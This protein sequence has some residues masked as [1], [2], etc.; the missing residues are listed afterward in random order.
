MLPVQPQRTLIEVSSTIGKISINVI[1]V[2]KPKAVMTI[3]H[4]AGAGME[5]PFMESLSQELA[6]ESI[7]TVR[8]NFP[9]MENRRGRPDPAPIAEKTVETVINKTHELY[10]RLPVFVSGKSF[11]G[12]MSSQRLSKD[13]PAFVKGIIFLGFPLHPAGAPA[14]DRAN[15]L[16]LISIPMLFLQ[17]TRDALAEMKLMEP[18]QKKL[19]LATLKKFEGADHSFKVSK[20][21]LLPELA[22]EA[23]LWIDHLI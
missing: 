9:Y 23:S 15:H 17:G 16:F 4:G 20:K 18:L 2:V 3:A 21:Q 10:P 12:R 14:T 7:S 8:F 11:G 1:D 5:H 13:C 19:P 6:K 22:R